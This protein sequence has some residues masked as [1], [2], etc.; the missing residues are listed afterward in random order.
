VDLFEPDNPESEPAVTISEESL[1]IVDTR[2][3]AILESMTDGF[4]ALDTKWRFVYLNTRAEELLQRPRAQL[5]GKRIWD[6]FPVMAANGLSDKYKAVVETRTP[7][8]FEA[9]Y[10]SLNLWLET[11]AYPADG[12]LIVYFHDIT[13]KKQVANELR[14]SEQ[15]FRAVWESSAEAMALSDPEGTVLAANP[16][17]YRLY[18]F[19]PEEVVGHNYAVIFPEMERRAAIRRYKETFVGG[20]EQAAVESIIRRKDGSLRQVEAT[21]RFIL[22]DGRRVA[23]LSQIRD[24][25]EKRNSQALLE[26]RLSRLGAVMNATSEG[27]FGLDK[28]ANCTFL[29]P[30]AVE[31]LGYTEEECLGRNV[32]EII[33]YKHLDGSPYPFEECHTFRV[34]R[35]EGSVRLVDETMW[36][37]DGT[38]LP[39]LYSCSPKLEGDHIVGCVISIVDISERRQAERERAQLLAE[40]QAARAAAERAVHAQEALLLMVSHDLR[41][42][43]TVIQGVAQLAQRRLSK[44]IS[45][46][47]KQLE[48]QF[49]T[50]A[51]AATKM[52]D[53]IHDLLTSGGL[54]P[55][56]LLSV[57][58]VPMD[59]VQLARKVA[60]MHQ[61][62]TQKHRL[63]VE[64]DELE[65]IGQWDPVRLEQVLDNLISNSVKSSPDGGEIKI[66]ISRQNRP[67]SETQT[68]RQGDPA[69]N[70]EAVL[71]IQDKGIGILEADIPHIFEWYRRG[72]N[73]SDLIAGSGV[74]LA[75][76]RQIVEQHGGRISVES[77]EG[78]GSTFTLVLPLNWW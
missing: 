22:E 3:T 36:R 13:D 48:T 66:M 27:I 50:I 76:V 78:E 18:G 39:V 62:Q 8:R 64:S 32:H 74:G 6:E 35:G 57:T 75:G 46:D 40:E 67:A 70:V 33:H 45:P 25:T 53:F 7:A 15:R 51:E 28:M 21:Y 59:L 29:N 30:A 71:R 63:V 58:P 16:A 55:G 43:L 56:Q 9:F 12:G 26:A 38:P 24:V 31:L 42:P 44:G 65:L 41:N 73:V 1:R 20:D 61:E 34:L 52:K 5:L 72:A 54:Q 60:A 37:K 17:Y 14:E 68:G 23:M 10:P 77:V 4:I 69:A 2:A 47:P 49:A 11:H 19:T